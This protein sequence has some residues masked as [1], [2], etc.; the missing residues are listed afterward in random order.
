M[1]EGSMMSAK[2][3][4][5]MNEVLEAVRVSYLAVYHWPSF[6]KLYMLTMWLN[7]PV[8]LLSLSNRPLNLHS[9]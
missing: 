2:L 1:V 5:L 6:V 9:F 8:N 7:G 4:D 3:L